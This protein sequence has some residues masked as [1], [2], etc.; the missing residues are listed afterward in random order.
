MEETDESNKKKNKRYMWIGLACLFVL[1][2]GY[3]AL[4]P[5]NT[6][7]EDT[8]TDTVE[9]VTETQQVAQPIKQTAKSKECGD[10]ICGLTEDY[11]NCELDCL[12]T[13]GDGIVQE[14]ETNNN[15][16]VDISS[17]CGDGVCDEWECY[18]FCRDCPQC[19]SDKFNQYDGPNE[20][21]PCPRAG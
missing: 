11:G 21:P 1:I 8:P 14:D 5:S 17:K 10:G 15:C 3:Y 9:Q 16:R 13:C 12:E 7:T 19:V 6:V 4:R 20:C 18:E 2:V